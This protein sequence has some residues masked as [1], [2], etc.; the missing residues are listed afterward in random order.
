MGYYKGCYKG[1]Y[2]GYQKGCYDSV[3]S[4]GVVSLTVVFAILKKETYIPVRVWRTARTAPLLSW[5]VHTLAK[6]GRP[7]TAIR[8]CTKARALSEAARTFCTILVVPY[9]NYTLKTKKS[10]RRLEPSCQVTGHEAP[11]KKSF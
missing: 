1:Y 4:W 5:L 8:T 3:G 9:Y 10:R 11:E 6:L 2:K 7:L